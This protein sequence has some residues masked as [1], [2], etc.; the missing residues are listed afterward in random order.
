MKLKFTSLR[1]LMQAPDGQPRRPPDS[2]AVVE[3]T[4]LRLVEEAIPDPGK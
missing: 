2:L 1:L 3:E 4:L